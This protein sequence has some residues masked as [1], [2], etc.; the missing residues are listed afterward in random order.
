MTKARAPR[1][2]RLELPVA[3]TADPRTIVSGGQSDAGSGLLDL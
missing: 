1:E 3:F 2:Q